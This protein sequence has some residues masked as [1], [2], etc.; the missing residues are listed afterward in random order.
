MKN[1]L[2]LL[3]LIPF[4]SFAQSK[5][6]KGANT[7]I[8]Q[9][10]S[11]ELFTEIGKQLIQDGWEIAESNSDFQTIST[12]WREVGW[13][14]QR[15]IISV[16]DGGIQIQGRLINEGANAVLNNTGSDYI[17]EWKKVGVNREAWERMEVFASHFGTDRMYLKK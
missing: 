17:L 5:P 8:V 11:T 13:I 6:F 12:G 3:L 4:L 2:I 10:E 14:K 7:L 9:T 16:L 1:F 15:M